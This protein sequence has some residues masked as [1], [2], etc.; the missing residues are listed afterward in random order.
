MNLKENLVE[1]RR[2]YHRIAEPGWMEFK[3]TINI[4][5]TLKE[6]G[7]KKEDLPMLA[8]QAIDDVCTAG[9]PRN[10]TEQDILALYQEAYE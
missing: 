5:Q 7:I 1:S 4:I 9:N 10:V 8:H 6:I 2:F 3:T